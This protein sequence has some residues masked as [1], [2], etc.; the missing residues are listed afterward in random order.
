MNAHSHDV[1]ATICHYKICL[2]CFQQTGS[3][4]KWSSGPWQGRVSSDKLIE[5]DWWDWT[6]STWCGYIWLLGLFPPYFSEERASS[7]EQA[8]SR[9]LRVRDRI[10]QKT[11]SFLSSF[12]LWFFS[13]NK[14]PHFPITEEAFWFMLWDFHYFP[15]LSSSD[16]NWRC[17]TVH[18][19]ATLGESI[20]MEVGSS[21]LESILTPFS[22]LP[23]L[24]PQLSAVSL[25]DEPWHH[26]I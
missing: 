25:H 9:Y 12:C 22:R 1:W 5:E 23:V 21:E 17:W 6:D 15:S 24:T 19:N 10:P 18:L 8:A 2:C 16:C 7:L 26:R 20:V 14:H 3:P 4:L 13:W 11:L